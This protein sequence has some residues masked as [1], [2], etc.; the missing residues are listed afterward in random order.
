M[1][2]YEVKLKRP[3]EETVHMTVSV[4]AETEH[5]AIEKAKQIAIERAASW[6]LD[7]AS[8]T[9]LGEITVESIEEIVDLDDANE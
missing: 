5:E 3:I 6:A 2:C 4:D 8:G 7:I 1:K 9:R